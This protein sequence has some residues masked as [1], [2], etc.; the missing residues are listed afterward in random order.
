MQALILAAGRS[1]R[2]YPFNTSHKSCVSI[3]GKSII[4]HTIESVA[5]SGIKDIVVVVSQNSS[6]KKILGEGKKFGVKIS[7]IVQENPTGAGDAILQAR[8]Y[9]TSDFYLLNANRIEFASFADLLL[10]KK[11]NSDNIVLLARKESSLSSFG[12]LKIDGDTVLSI[13][14]KPK[15]GEEPSDLKVVGLYLLPPSFI[16]LLTTVES[17]H[18]SLENAISKAAGQGKVKFVE[19]SQDT[20]SLKYPWDLLTIKDYLLKNSTSS[21]SKNANIAQGAQIIGKV[22]VEDG[23]RIMEGAVIKGPAYIGKNV[24]VGT[25]AII[26]GKSSIEEG[27]VIG[28]RMEIKNSLIGKQT[29]THSGFIGDSVIGENCKI[30]AQ[31]CTANVRLDRENVTIKTETGKIDTLKQSLGVIMGENVFAGIRV[32]TMPGVIIGRNVTIGPQTVVMHNLEDDITFYSTF[33]ETV[34]K[35]K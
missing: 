7:Y 5:R 31:F 18:Y 24:T 1:S 10:E 29:T 35:K 25:N 22:V 20:V 21:I 14:E 12:T 15:K 3:L 2:F 13:V 16:D 32:S 28:A 6:V 26:R 33:S 34:K 11:K 19:T 8:D 4:E 23:A 17:D 27:A 9:I 30:A